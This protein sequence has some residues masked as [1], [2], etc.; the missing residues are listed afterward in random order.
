MLGR[1]ISVQNIYFQNGLP[2]GRVFIDKAEALFCQYLPKEPNW[3]LKE[4]HVAQTII[5]KVVEESVFNLP[6]Y[7]CNITNLE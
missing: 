6:L 5:N 3:Q 7:L 1:D 4:N 2:P